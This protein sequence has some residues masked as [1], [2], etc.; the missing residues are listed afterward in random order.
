MKPMKLTSDGLMI[1]YYETLDDIAED[2]E[3]A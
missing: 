2:W 1:A 3:K